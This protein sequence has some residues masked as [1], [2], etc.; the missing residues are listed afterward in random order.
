MATR[1]ATRPEQPSAGAIAS[2]H[3]SPTPCPGETLR[4]GDGAYGIAESAT[5]RRVVVADGDHSAAATTVDEEDDPDL[6][7]GIENEIEIGELRLRVVQACT[8]FDGTGNDRT[9]GVVWPAGYELAK[10]AASLDLENA[11]VVE[12]GCG[13]ALP[14][15]AA[16]STAARVVATDASSATLRR[17]R[18]VAAA[19]GLTRVAFERLEWPESL[20][21]K[22][23]WILAADCVY[24]RDVDDFVRAVCAHLKPRGKA[25]V[26]VRDERLGVAEFVEAIGK[27]CKQTATWTVTPSEDNGVP[28]WT[29]AERLAVPTRFFVYEFDHAAT[30]A[31]K[32]RELAQCKAA[33]KGLQE[34]IVNL[35]RAFQSDM[36]L[37]QQKLGASPP[38]TSSP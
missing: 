6:E 29:T 27:R 19:N 32:R 33:M 16:A 26:A 34:D 1:I 25:V 38:P 8:A 14:S 21:E 30:L 24:G 4:K 7:D 15:L 11:T 10:Y 37:L 17:A 13:L 23:D 9:G 28:A 35:T 36:R 12:L 20:A 2:P 18:R 3:R 22:F 31:D 5:D